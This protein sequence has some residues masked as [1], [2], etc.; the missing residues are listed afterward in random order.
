MKRTVWLV[1]SALLLPVL[2]FAAEGQMGTIRGKIASPDQ[3]P[4]RG[5]VSLWDGSEG[6]TPDPRR[7]LII[8]FSAVNLRPSCEFELQAPAGSYYVGALL[9]NSPG[10]DLGPPRMGDLVFM[11]PDSQG[12]V[13][14]IA[15]AGG[16]TLE[17]GTHG[18]G[19][20][21]EGMLAESAL[22]VSGTVRDADGCPV[23]GVLVFAFADV[24]MTR[25]PLAVSGRTDE[26]G[27]YQL[28]IDRP[29]QVYLRVK[30]DCGGGAPAD[31]GYVGVFGG[32][33]PVVV[34]VSGDALITGRDIQVFKVPAGQIRGR[35]AA[36]PMSREGQSPD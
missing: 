35:G 23:P 1:L 5:V 21:Y 34:E 6:R 2:V 4:C 7:Y 12:E 28:R 26:N 17:L 18:E 32:A 14:K 22:G 16:K 19:W 29:G 3:K 10:P 13:V 9:R 20:R 25:S 15:V 8:P 33:V 36:R 30:D 24:G 27:R 31:G 11:T